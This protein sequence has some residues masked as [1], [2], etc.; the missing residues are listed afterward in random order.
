M[1][2]SLLPGKKRGLAVKASPSS[3]ASS[4]VTGSVLCACGGRPRPGGANFCAARRPILT[5]SRMAPH[6]AFAAYWREPRDLESSQ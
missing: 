3:S 6:T 4:P 2:L 1:S 5:L